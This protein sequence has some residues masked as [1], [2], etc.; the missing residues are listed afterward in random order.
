MSY[1]LGLRDR[2]RRTGR[3]LAGLLLASLSAGLL[4]AG[5]AA[6]QA[7]APKALRT[8]AS[9]SGR[10]FHVEEATIADVHRAIQQGETT[11]KA[12]VQSYIERARAYDGTCVRLVTRDGTSIPA[13]TGMVM[14]PFGYGGW[15]TTTA[16]SVANSWLNLNSI[17]QAMLKPNWA[18]ACE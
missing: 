2:H 6:G 3:L 15:Q 5:R 13:V 10:T 14:M 12:I 17:S 8:P 1:L 9:R 18:P 16:G 11:C 4:S 7:T